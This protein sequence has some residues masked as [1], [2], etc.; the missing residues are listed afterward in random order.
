VADNQFVGAKVETTATGPAGAVPQATFHGV[1]F[2]CNR[3]AGISGSCQPQAPDDGITCGTDADCPDPLTCG[4]GSYPRGFGAVVAQTGAAPP[5]ASF[6]DLA[7]AGENAFTLNRKTATGA[8]FHVQVPGASVSALG[9]QWESC[10]TGVTCDTTAVA[11]DDI[12]VAAGATVD[13]GTPP[14]PRALVPVLSSVSPARPRRGDLVRVYGANFNAIEGTDCAGTTTP[15]EP[16]SGIDPAVETQNQASNANRVRIFG[17][18]GMVLATLFPDAVTPTMIAFRM[19]FD[20]FA[21]LLLQIAKRDPNDGRLVAKPIGL[22][23]PDGCAGQPAGVSCDDRNVCTTN[24]RC[25]GGD[26]GVCAGDAVP[27]VGQCLTGACDPRGGC[28]PRPATTACEDGDACTVSDHCSGSGDRCVSGPS[29]S[30]GSACLTGRCDPRAGCEPRAAGSV[31]RS[32]A[33]VCDVAETCDGTTPDCP[34]D[35]FAGGAVVCRPAADVCDAEERCTGRAAGC[36]ADTKRIDVCRPAASACDVAERCDGVQDACPADVFAPD[37][38]PCEDGD[39]CTTGGCAA[40]VCVSTPLPRFEHAICAL[41][42]L[43]AGPLCGADRVDDALAAA[44]VRRLRNDARWLREASTASDSSRANRLVARVDRSL[45]AI[46]RRA[47][48]AVH[49]RKISV[50]CGGAIR[51]AIG[52]RRALVGGLRT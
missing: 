23:D 9:N 4:T 27:C 46:Q 24:D 25:T 17:A 32:A 7:R 47:L 43:V 15:A 26:D 35:G 49:A 45:A 51:T 39:P 19:P 13:I 11:T 38:I 44:V 14:G 1:A 6:G 52:E 37:G 33:G 50:A 31:C 22:C 36:P 21:P 34:P 48:R 42:T 30:C 2:V 20:C 5:A 28:V 10:K 41:Q 12:R 3:N 8:N 29:R 18:D 16:C 40:G